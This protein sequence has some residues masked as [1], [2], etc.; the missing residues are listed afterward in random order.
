MTLRAYVS[1]AASLNLSWITQSGVKSAGKRA[2]KANEVN[3]VELKDIPDDALA[4][5]VESDVDFQ[6]AAGIDASDDGSRDF[7]FVNAA[8]PYA[9]SALALPAEVQ[10]HVS[11]VNA[12]S[13]SIELSLTAYDEHGEPAGTRDIHLEGDSAVMLSPTDI[14]KNA[15]AL[16]TDYQGSDLVW[17]AFLTNDK[18]SSSDH[19]GLAYVGAER[20]EVAKQTVRAMHDATIMR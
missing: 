3:V 5:L 19:E 2:M 11:M 14:S 4:L 17:G 6:A 12:S 8:S 10:A 13:K 15:V 7:A 1:Q 9:Q 16:S 18:V 20:L